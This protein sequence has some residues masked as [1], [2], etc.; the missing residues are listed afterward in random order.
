VIGHRKTILIQ[1]VKLLVL[2][3]MSDLEFLKQKICHQRVPPYSQAVLTG[4]GVLKRHRVGKNMDLI[5]FEPHLSI[6]SNSP[7]ISVL[8]LLWLLSIHDIRGPIGMDSRVLHVLSNQTTED[9][10]FLSSPSKHIS[11]EEQTEGLQ[12]LSEVLMDPGPF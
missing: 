1:V 4:L 6:C 9:F 2:L 10:D 11:K 7:T 12:P 5:Q 3:D 8:G